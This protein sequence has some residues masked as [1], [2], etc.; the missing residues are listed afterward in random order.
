MTGQGLALRPFRGTDEDYDALVRIDRVAWP[1]EPVSAESLRFDDE[2][3]EDDQFHERVF[4]E[5]DGEPVAYAQYSETPW[6]YEPGK[7]FLKL[8]VRP[9]FQRQGIGGMLYAHVEALLLNRGARLLTATTRE[10]LSDAVRFLTRRGFRQVIRELESRLDVHAFD[11]GAFEPALEAV[12]ASGVDIVTIAALRETDPDWL[13][14]WYDLRWQIIPDMPTSETF[15][16]ESIDDF[17]DGLE[18]P[19]IDLDA[20]YVAVDRVTGT[21]AGLSSVALLPDDPA[22]LYVGSTGVLRTYRRRGIALALKVHTVD[23]ARAYGAATIIG[24]NEEN[25]PMY[26]LNEKLGF[27]FSRA[28]LGFEKRVEQPAG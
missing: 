18:S 20:V 12:R 4:A 9:A 17:A 15:T 16:P 19:E 21:W 27:R 28:W 26:R 14:K 13:R 8:M 25:N 5:V 7:Y 24:E 22:S 1:D 2:E 10:S 11:R 6:A 23:F 3:W